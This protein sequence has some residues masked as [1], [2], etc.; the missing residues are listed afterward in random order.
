MPKGEGPEVEIRCQLTWS[1]DEPD[2]QKQLDTRAV[3]AGSWARGGILK[4][5]LDLSRGA[6]VAL[7][8]N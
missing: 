1:S 3:G 7:S 6:T 5:V 8:R 2:Q 4:W